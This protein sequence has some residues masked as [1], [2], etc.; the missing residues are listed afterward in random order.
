VSHSE[1]QTYFAFNY[2]W[3]HLTEA[4]NASQSGYYYFIWKMAA[5][6]KSAN[7]NPTIGAARAKFLARVAALSSY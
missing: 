6:D 2:A 4:S 1:L 5:T 3:C 7:N